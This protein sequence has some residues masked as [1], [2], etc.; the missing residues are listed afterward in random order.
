MVVWRDRPHVRF[1]RVRSRG[2]V[3]N[4]GRQDDDVIEPDI[5]ARTL[6][7][8]V[9][10][11]VPD[12]HLD[13][14]HILRI[15][16][17]HRPERRRRSVSLRRKL[18]LRVL[19]P[20]GAERV[21]LR[22]AT[23]CNRVI[24]DQSSPAPKAEHWP[25]MRAVSLNGAILN[26]DVVLVIKRRER[27]ILQRRWL[28]AVAVCIGIRFGLSIWPVSSFE[29]NGAV[30]NGP[31]ARFDFVSYERVTSRFQGFVLVKKVIQ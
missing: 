30:S 9:A 2:H 10:L 6:D 1:V 16:P 21:A 31:T 12:P 20:A 5:P 29:C 4:C 24:K 13:S 18:V 25:T 19:I 11:V 22:E 27:A 15:R 3:V 8:A 23:Y 14:V 28:I 7:D 26:R 17:L